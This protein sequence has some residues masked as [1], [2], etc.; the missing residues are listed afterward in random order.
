MH[1][2]AVYGQVMALLEGRDGPQQSH[3]RDLRADRGWERSRNK[4]QA[5][6]HGKDVVLA[7]GQ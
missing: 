4:C 2:K 7:S 6:A 5:G 3:C 1:R